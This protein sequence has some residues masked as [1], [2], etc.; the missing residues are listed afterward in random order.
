MELTAAQK[1]ELYEAVKAVLVNVTWSDAAELIAL[2]MASATLKQ[3]VISAV[4]KYFTNKKHSVDW[5]QINFSV[6]YSVSVDDKYV[7]KFN[8]T[9]AVAIH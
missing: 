8:Y 7:S 6:S 4:I 3:K 5:C 9:S 1:Q 2:V